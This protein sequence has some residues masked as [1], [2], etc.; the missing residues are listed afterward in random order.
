MEA[1]VEAELGG[2]VGGGQGGREGGRQIPGAGEHFVS[3]WQRQFEVDEERGRVKEQGQRI[4]ND[5]RFAFAFDRQREGGGRQKLAALQQAVRELAATPLTEALR[6][7]EPVGL[8]RVTSQSIRA[9]YN[10]P[11]GAAAAPV[12]RPW[13]RGTAAHAALLRLVAGTGLQADDAAQAQAAA[14][15]AELGRGDTDPSVMVVEVGQK[16]RAP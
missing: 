14:T 5:T 12:W 3:A 16:R 11:P 1:E 6:R 4:E 15:P 9:K 8:G 7:N 13:A 2:E 10:P